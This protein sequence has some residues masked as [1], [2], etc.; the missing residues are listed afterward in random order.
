MKNT[1]RILQAHTYKCTKKK[2]F[3]LKK[4]LLLPPFP[5]NHMQP[6]LLLAVL[7][8]TSTIDTL[9]TMSLNVQI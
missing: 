6:T 3:L 7:P 5:Q 1:Q 4:L 9:A 2:K 8:N